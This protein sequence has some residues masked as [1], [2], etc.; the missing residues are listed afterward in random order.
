MEENPYEPPAAFRPH[1]LPRPQLKSWRQACRTSLLTSLAGFAAFA[2]MVLADAT[3]NPNGWLRKIEVVLTLLS[4]SVAVVGAAVTVIAAIG[5]F[6]AR[7][8]W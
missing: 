4:M 7:A 6:I 5:W 8:L 2:L 1:R 3:F